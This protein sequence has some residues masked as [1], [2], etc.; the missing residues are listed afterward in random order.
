MTAEAQERA[1][2][3]WNVIAARDAAWVPKADAEARAEVLSRRF[4]KAISLE[5]K[6]QR[7]QA[8]AAANEEFRRRTEEAR[9]ASDAFLA[10]RWQVTA[11][12]L[13]EACSCYSV[14]FAGS[15][16]LSAGF[17]SLVERLLASASGGGGGG[18]CSS[19]GGRPG[20]ADEEVLREAAKAASPPRVAS[21]ITGV[22]QALFGGTAA[23]SSSSAEAPP[24]GSGQASQAEG[25]ALPAGGEGPRLSEA[26]GEA[27]M[28]QDVVEGQR[29][30]VW[31]SSNSRWFDGVVEKVFKEAGTADGYSVPA[32]V[33]QVSFDHGRKFIR[34]D[35][36]ATHMR[37][38]AAAAAAAG[39]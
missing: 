35:Q 16:L 9:A 37:K 5:E 13:R 21:A 1:A 2:A 38:I 18:G 4:G 19:A 23:A 26:E 12:I 28:H 7:L 20:G 8:K 39:A 14:I 27:V 24:A 22:V 15:S 3:V 34:P 6:K 33:I 11:L 25:P 29:V 32:G 36:A 31:S 30:E 17:G 10:E